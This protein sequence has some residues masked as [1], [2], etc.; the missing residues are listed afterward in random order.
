M[1]GMKGT[2]T[3]Q[4]ELTQLTELT[5]CG[6]CLAAPARNAAHSAAG[7]WRQ[8]NSHREFAHSACQAVVP[9]TPPIAGVGT[10]AGP[11]C[12]FCPKKENYFVEDSWA[13]RGQSTTVILSRPGGDPPPLLRSYGGTR[14]QPCRIRV[15]PRLHR[16][17]F[18]L[19][20]SSETKRW[21]HIQSTNHQIIESS[22]LQLRPHP[23]EP[24]SIG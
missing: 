18:G 17:R 1:R 14:A 19:R 13:S 11:F 4:T 10:K 22:L 2:A 20:G 12:K 3:T 24:D 6:C 9:T 21:P 15:F 8:D 16:L 7:G 5:A 23:E